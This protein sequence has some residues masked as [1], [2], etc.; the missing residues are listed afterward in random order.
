MAVNLAAKSGL[1]N[2][3]HCAAI[4]SGVSWPIG[5]TWPPFL[6]DAPQPMSPASSSTT[7]TPASARTRP[8]RSPVK[9]APMMATSQ[10]ISVFRGIVSGAVTPVAAQRESGNALGVIDDMDLI[11]YRIAWVSTHP[12][13]QILARYVLAVASA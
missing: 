1:P 12:E 7:L 9:P 4:V 3:C 8:A 6:P 5:L 11:N 13:C 2:A 10:S